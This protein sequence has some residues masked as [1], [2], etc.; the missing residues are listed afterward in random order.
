MKALLLTLVGLVSFCLT[1]TNTVAGEQ[2]TFIKNSNTAT[3]IAFSTRPAP[4][5]F[6]VTTNSVQM[7][8]GL[9]FP[10]SSI[11]LEHHEPYFTPGFWDRIEININQPMSRTSGRDWY[12]QPLINLSTSKRFEDCFGAGG[13]AMYPTSNTRSE[14]TPKGDEYGLFIAFRFTF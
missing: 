2:I 6:I 11:S 4:T 9:G 10:R 5:A 3:K 1:T 13:Y 14:T 7:D 8:K 12:F